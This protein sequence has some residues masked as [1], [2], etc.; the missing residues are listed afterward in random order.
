MA[1]EEMRDQALGNIQAKYH[2]ISVYLKASSLLG[3]VAD[4]ASA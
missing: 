4:S 2:P 3:K 1:R